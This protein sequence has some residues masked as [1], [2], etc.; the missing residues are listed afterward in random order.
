VLIINNALARQ[1]FPNEDPIGKRCFWVS[2]PW[3]R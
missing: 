3:S 2:S 1:H